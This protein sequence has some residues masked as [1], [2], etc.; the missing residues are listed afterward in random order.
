MSD[1]LLVTPGSYRRSTAYWTCCE[2]LD[3]RLEHEMEIV[4]PTS[5]EWWF[6]RYVEPDW[7]C[8]DCLDECRRKFCTWTSFCKDCWHVME[9]T[10][11]ADFHVSHSPC[12]LPRE[13]TQDK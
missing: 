13:G 7:V 4:L 1:N 6:E 8:E 9:H 2:C 5:G 12:P 3:H 10:L 11:S